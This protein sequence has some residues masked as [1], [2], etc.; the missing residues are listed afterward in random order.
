[1]ISNTTHRA[2]LSRRLLLL[3]AL[4]AAGGAQ[5]AVF[6]VATPAELQQALTAAA[7]SPGNDEIRIRT[8]VYAA[9]NAFLYSS[10]NPGW[11]QV[12][13]G[14]QPSGDEPCATRVHRAD[15][16]V[17]DGEG[18]RRAL[19]LVYFNNTGPV[20]PIRPQFF[21]DNLRLA[22]GYGNDATFERGGG[23]HL[24]AFSHHHVSVWLDNLIIEN[25]RGYF[26]GG[27]EVYLSHGGLR[28]TNSLFLDNG[29]P[30]TAGA[31]L[32][33]SIVAT[34]NVSAPAA[35]IASSTF[36]GGTCPGQG[37]RGCG[38]LMGIG[39]GIH[40]DVLNSLFWGN[41]IADISLEGLAHIGN[42]I[43]TA[44]L[45]STL[46][47]VLSGNLAPLVQ[48][49]LTGDPRF[50]EPGSGDFRLRDDSPFIDAGLAAV[51]QLPPLDL[52]GQPRVR[53]G[54]TDPGPYE[55]QTWDFLFAD[56]FQGQP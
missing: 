27:A 38:I 25:S 37:T 15:A 41:A 26:A 35:T 11:L 21:I 34:D 8:G 47:P 2:F 36:A 49:P 16:T 14:W 1:M 33:I 28:I 56:G 7:N 40:L 45:D 53:F 12:S 54:I 19:R 18:Q 46:A 24:S 30:T 22:N 44:R 52:D 17:L 5:A 48:R 4:L 42:G 32:S 43:G 50:V 10:Q 31:H 3:L 51:A 29:A 13:G 55:N 6:C 20:P 23:L 9:P 39:E